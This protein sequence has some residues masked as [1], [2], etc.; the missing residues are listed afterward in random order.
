MTRTRR[1][2]AVGVGLLT[3]VACKPFWAVGAVPTFSPLGPHVVVSWPPADPGDE[4][5]AIA[6]YRVWV[7]G[8]EVAQV[9]GASTE[10]VLVGLAAS[11]TYDIEV[12]AVDTAAEDSAGVGGD[13]VTGVLAGTYLTP[14]G[15]GGGA[16]MDCVATTDSDGDRLPDA[17]ETDT[18][19]FADAGDTGT[20]P[21]H[22]DTDGDYISDGDEVLG[23]EAG[24][25][26]PAFGISPLR[27]DVLLEYDWFDDNAD[28]GTCAA[29]SHRP[30]PAIASRVAQTFSS[31]PH[32]N[33][34]GSTGIN[35]VQDYGQDAVHT[36]GNL[37]ADANGVIA[38]GVNGTE[39]LGHK[40]ANFA[41]ER[42]GYFHY[43]LLPHRYNTTSGSSGQAELPGDDMIVSL[44]CWGTTTNVGNTIVHEL[45]H[46]LFLRHGG[47]EDTN[48]MPNYNSV[49][50]YLFQFPGVDTDCTPAG[51]GVADYSSGDRADLDEHALHEADGICGGVALDWNGNSVLDLSPVAVDINGDGSLSVLTDHDDWGNI[52]F[53]G[54]FVTSDGAPVG[55]RLPDTEIISEQPVP[56]HAQ[57]VP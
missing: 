18:G 51:N 41:P 47:D 29:H 25:D 43:V 9:P 1:V 12:T 15:G 6:S 8:A 45:G 20:D 5:Q 10:C 38:G 27:A 36:G 34:D 57:Q 39:F 46:N 52:E 11:T 3:A 53:F 28:P 40:A 42:Q 26:L 4:G 44:Q 56:P 31:S 35:V 17:R 49:M 22:W 48:Y 24:L 37:V 13:A 7:D 14:G 55:P 2:L 33:P 19:T 32:V 23:T 16:T 30:T 50:N 54:P 21:L